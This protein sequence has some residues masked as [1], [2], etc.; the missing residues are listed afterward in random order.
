MRLIFRGK[1]I[2]ICK[3][4]ILAYGKGAL[5]DVKKEQPIGVFDSGLGGISVLR[6]LVS[7]L[8]KEDFIYFGDAAHA[9]YGERTE[10][11]IRALT[12]AQIDRMAAEGVKAVVLACNTATSAAC[13]PLRRR[14]RQMPIIG[15]EPALKPAVLSGEKPRVVVMATHATL[16]QKKFARLM[17]RFKD[18]G[19]IVKLPCPEIVEFVERGE[20]RSTALH[21]Y[22]EERFSSVSQEPIDCVV[23]GCTHFP[24][25]REAIQDVVG[26]A[27]QIFDGAAGTARE[28]KRRLLEADA[29]RENGQK[30]AIEWLSSSSDPRYIERAKML[31]AL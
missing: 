31:Y 21:E 30:G 28:L 4:R 6:E 9:P 29:L 8:P 10:R 14:Y 7:L 11:E 15:M 23:L 19:E 3:R 5:D 26:Q 27:V 24:F 17:E 20:I 18:A 25:V 2:R 13:A 16:R 22:L 1:L 12:T